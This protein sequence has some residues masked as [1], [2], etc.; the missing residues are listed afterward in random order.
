MDISIFK[1]K[2]AEMD[3]LRL[4]KFPEKYTL[5]FDRWQKKGNSA[6]IL[7]FCHFKETFLTIHQAQIYLCIFPPSY[8]NYG[9]VTAMPK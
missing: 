6:S 7:I 8:C 3:L 9:S 4:N 2:Y 5:C 1:E